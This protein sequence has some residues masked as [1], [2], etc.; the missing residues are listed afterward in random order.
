MP[1]LD[2][3]SVSLTSS[4]SYVPL[5]K[6]T[7][8]HKALTDHKSERLKK[9]DDAVKNNKFFKN[10][11]GP[12]GFLFGHSC[13]AKVEAIDHILRGA[14]ITRE[15]FSQLNDGTLGKIMVNPQYKAELPQNYIDCRDEIEAE[16]AHITAHM[17]KAR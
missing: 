6:S 10:Y 15:D 7:G 2:P 16:R 4:S 13:D 8:L 5:S 3:H 17:F 12:V 9:K 11:Y 1:I 14:P